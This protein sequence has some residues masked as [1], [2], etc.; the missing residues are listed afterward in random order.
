MNLNFALLQKTGGEFKRPEQTHIDR[1]NFL[2]GRYTFVIGI[3]RLT[4]IVTEI[5]GALQ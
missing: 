2:V 5:V 3:K 1:S 4:L